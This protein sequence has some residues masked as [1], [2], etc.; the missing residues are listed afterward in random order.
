MVMN[1]YVTFG[2]KF[3]HHFTGDGEVIILVSQWQSTAAI[4]ICS[5]RGLW[6]CNLFQLA[7]APSNLNV[8]RAALVVHTRNAVLFTLGLTVAW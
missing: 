1:C 3:K 2:A 4:R 7:V 8:R 5:K 6:A